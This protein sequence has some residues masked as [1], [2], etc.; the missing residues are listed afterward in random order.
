[1]YMVLL[2]VDDTQMNIV[3]GLKLRVSPHDV[4]G[5]AGSFQKHNRNQIVRCNRKKHS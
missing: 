4:L 1:M 2:R 3:Y 5:T